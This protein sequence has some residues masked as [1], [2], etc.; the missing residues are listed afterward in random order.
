MRISDGSSDVSSSDPEDT[1]IYLFGTVHALPREL[2]WNAGAVRDAFDS[3]GTLVVEVADDEDAASL[4]PMLKLG[5]AEPGSVTPL[6][7]RVPEKEREALKALIARTPFPPQAMDR[8]ETWL[9]A[10][11]LVAPTLAA[12][13][14]DPPTGADRVL[15]ASAQKRGIAVVGLETTEEQLGY[16]DKLPEADQRSLL[17][18][19]IEEEGSMKEQF[20]QL[21]AAWARGDVTALEELADA[22]LKANP[23]VRKVLLTSRSEEHP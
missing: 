5:L 4:A 2:A 17:S 12:A 19:V 13:G 20:Q 10:L 15:M 11:F 7:E 14:L 21:I 6:R 18:A 22:A 23:N 8:F 3:A 1:T 16:F 9:A